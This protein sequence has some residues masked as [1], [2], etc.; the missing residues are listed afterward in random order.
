[1]GIPTFYRWLLDRYPRSIVYVKE[2]SP[3]VVNGEEV[4]IDITGPNPNAIEF[5]NLYL[6]LNGIIHPCFHPEDRPPP[7]SYDEVYKAIFK[8]IDHIFSLIRPRKLLFIAIDGVAPRAKMNQQRSRRY[9]TARDAADAAAMAEKSKDE[10]GTACEKLVPEDKIKKMDSNVITPGTEFMASLSVA[11]QYYIRLRLN[12]D[13]G[14]RGIKVILSDANVPGE[15]EHKVAAYIRD[16][17]NLPGFDPNTRHCLYGLDADLIMLALATHEIHFSVLREVIVFRGKQ[18]ENRD[19]DGNMKRSAVQNS[20]IKEAKEEDFDFIKRIRFQFVHIWILREYLD[21]ELRIPEASMKTN[22]ERLIDDFVFMCLF[23]GNDFLPHI[24]T[25][26]ITEGAIDLLIK[27]YKKEFNKMGGYLT[28]SCEVDLGRVEHFLQAL[29][30]HE[31]AILR[32]RLQV[33]WEK[34]TLFGKDACETGGDDGMGWMDGPDKPKLVSKDMSQKVLSNAERKED[35]ARTV[36]EGWKE[37]Y[38]CEKFDVDTPNDRT[39]LKDHAVQK[40][41][42]GICWFMHYYYQGICSWQWFYPYYYAPFSSDFTNLKNL[43][44]SFTM[45]KP[46]KPFDQLLGVLPAA[47]AYALPLSYRKLMTDTSSSIIDFYPQDFALDLNGKRFFWQAVCKLPFINESRLL[48]EIE[49]LEHT[50]TDEERKRNAFSLD[51]LFFHI[52]HRMAPKVISFYEEKKD[53]QKLTRAKL[54]QKIN[55]KLS[56]GMNGFAYISDKTIQLS[57]IYSPID[58]METIKDNQT[59]FVYYKGPP[60]HPHIPKVPEGTELP[61]K[62]ISMK[63]VRQAP[64]LWHEKRPAYLPSHRPTSNAIAGDRR[65]YGNNHREVQKVN[66]WQNRNQPRLY[67]RQGENTVKKDEILGKR[68]RKGEKRH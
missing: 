14:W 5:D 13:P 3:K 56:D 15:G 45:G 33:K 8:Y 40:Y 52:S 20:K 37:R 32:R 44:I 53:S 60:M 27:V 61:K 31:A 9:R 24:P 10:Y 65:F 54:K 30:S 6:D 23:V 22:L 28:N 39:K 67:S 36:E 26:E 4:P 51:S 63:D 41:V 35:K 25:L 64:P 48:R 7:S 42:E 29:G 16:Q 58:G 18:N 11:L 68:N 38:Y 12:T 17:R 57:E 50:L 55:P 46:F 1:M 62:L 2:E 66:N 34:D 43:D 47:S 59:I 49:S 21:F 19:R